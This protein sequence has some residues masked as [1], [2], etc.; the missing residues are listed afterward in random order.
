MAT[1]RWINAGYAHYTPFYHAF[2]NGIDAFWEIDADDTTICLNADKAAKAL[3]EAEKYLNDTSIGAV[4]LDMWWTRTHYK[5]WTWGV[6][7]VKGVSRFIEEFEQV[8]DKRWWDPYKDLDIDITADWFFTYLKDYKKMNIESF[9]IE[10]SWFIHWCSFI[11][12]SMFGYVC[13][14]SKGEWHAPIMEYIFNSPN[15]GCIGIKNCLKI[16]IGAEL[17]E[18]Q[19]FL[20]NYVSSTT[21]W[22]LELRKLLCLGEFSRDKYKWK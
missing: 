11:R 2:D 21:E 7:Y 10:N 5:Y 15:L 16:D 6:A 17:E 12:H 13:Y 20:E 4:S 3:I 22:P 1:P 14:W 9:Y 18:G 19:I 8:E